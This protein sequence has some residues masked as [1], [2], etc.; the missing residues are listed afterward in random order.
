MLREILDTMREERDA[1]RDQAGKIDARQGLDAHAHWL[2]A[3]GG[4]HEMP[5]ALDHVQAG[6]VGFARS[7]QTPITTS[8]SATIV[9]T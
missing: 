8:A 4:G 1:W 3:G 6:A 7:C 9:S 5:K 2:A